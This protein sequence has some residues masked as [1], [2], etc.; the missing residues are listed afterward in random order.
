MRKTR[1]LL[2][3]KLVTLHCRCNSTGSLK[4]RD[5]GRLAFGL[6]SLAAAVEEVEVGFEQL[7]YQGVGFCRGDGCNLLARSEDWRGRW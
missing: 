1:R 6:G 7:G 3:H 4:Y 2:G 5:F